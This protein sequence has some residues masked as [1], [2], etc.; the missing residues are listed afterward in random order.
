M[1]ISNRLWTSPICWGNRFSIR[2]LESKRRDNAT[3]VIFLIGIYKP[4]VFFSYWRFS[5]KRIFPDGCRR[6]LEFRKCV[7]ISKLLD[8]SS[9]KSMGMLRMWHHQRHQFSKFKISAAAMLNSGWQALCDVMDVLFIEVATF[10]PNLVKIGQKLS[11][12]HQFFKIQLAASVLLTVGY[13]SFFAN[14]DVYL[15]KV[16]TLIPNLMKI[17]QIMRERRHIFEIQFGGSRHLEFRLQVFFNIKDELFFKV[18]TFPT[19]LVGIAKKWQSGISFPKS[20]M[21]ADT[22]LK[23]TFPVEPPFWDFNSKSVSLNQKCNVCW[24]ASMFNGSLLWDRGL[25]IFSKCR[26]EWLRVS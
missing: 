3:K 15:F 2:A 7:A 16:A 5:R 14:I 18:A 6:P 17:G 25:Y 8:Q 13:Q 10:L 21:A 20:N 24:S 1:N 23:S 22:I 11:E 26:Q 12:R 9:P 19:T 4:G